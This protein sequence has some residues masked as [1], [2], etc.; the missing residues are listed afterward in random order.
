M[1]TNGLV[2]L[3]FTPLQGLS[4][5]VLQFIPDGDFE[6]PQKFVVFCTWDE[7]PHLSDE[8]KK[9]L[10]A[11]IPPY[12]RDARSKG[13][14]ALGSGAIYPVPESDVIVPDFAVPPHWSKAYGMDVGWNRTAAIWS[15]HNRETDTVYLWSEYYRGEAEPA[16]HVQAIQARG[17][18][19]QGAIDPASRGRS[20]VDGRQLI[21]MYTDLGLRLTKAENSVEAGIYKVW[22]R[23]SSG[24]LKVF[25][26][27]PQWLSE[28]R[29]YRRD[30]KG[31]VVKERD[32]LMDSYRYL[33]QEM[34][35]I[36]RVQP[37]KAGEEQVRRFS[38]GDR[39]GG[40]WM[41]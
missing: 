27:C 24:R 32:H 3:T 11:S 39:T 28:F 30:E 31:K 40:G 22:Q 5:V 2:M 1:T 10:W 20:Q 15:A 12:Q 25:A 26:S 37:A 4:E 35:N 17:A 23:L 13:L 19:I 6:H 33:E 9:E 38:F 8:V 41:A 7:V 34:V 18:W 14:P 16:V 21:Q 36:E 29:L